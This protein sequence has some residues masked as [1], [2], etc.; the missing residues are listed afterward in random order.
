MKT[1]KSSIPASILSRLFDC[2][3]NKSLGRGFLL[4]HTDN[5]GDINVVMQSE[6]GAISSAL[7]SK[8]GLFLD[9]MN[10]QSFS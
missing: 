2:S 7:M 4:V 1:E 9:K 8:A 6:T 5:N 10:E 3:G